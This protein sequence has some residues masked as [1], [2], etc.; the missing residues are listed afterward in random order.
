MTIIRFF[1]CFEKDKVMAKGVNV[2]L[3]AILAVLLTFTGSVLAGTYGGGNGE[4]NRPYLIAVDDLLEM[5]SEPGDW[6][7]HFKQTADIDLAGA[8]DNPDGSFSTAVIA[9]DTDSTKWY[10]DGTPFADIFGGNDHKIKNLTID[11]NG[12]GN[13]F[14]GLFGKIDVNSQVVNPELEDVNIIGGYRPYR[15]GGLCGENSGDINN[16]YATSSVAAGN[17]SKCLAGSVVAKTFRF[18]Q[19]SDTQPRGSSDWQDMKDAIAIINSLKPD[20]VFLVGDIT[21]FGTESECE[22]ASGLLKGIKAPLYIVPGNHDTMVPYDAADRALAYDEIHA[23]RMANY[24]Q[25]YGVESWS[26][27]IGDFQFVGFDSTEVNYDLLPYP[28]YEYNKDLMTHG[29]FWPYISEARQQWLLE[30]CQNS[31][32]PYKFLVIHY[33]SVC[34]RCILTHD[35]PYHGRTPYPI[36]PDHIDY[37][38][39]EAVVIGQMFG[40]RHLL[41]AGQDPTT[42]QL[43]FDSCTTLGLGGGVMYFDVDK[44]ILDCFWKPINGGAAQSMGSYNLDTVRAMVLGKSSSARSR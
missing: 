28:G 14:L 23:I 40:H 4:P 18:V 43:M 5:R 35:T 21:W 16:C 39:G 24:N 25:Y 12:I 1:G 33:P 9:W 10:L 30:T 2:R 15:L 26:V 11:T 31:S 42:G 20:I 6:G 44:N 8:G 19:F 17:S 7:K 3:M 34:H 29:P 41:E 37:T 36:T 32:K 27:E 22:Q 38:L 13:D